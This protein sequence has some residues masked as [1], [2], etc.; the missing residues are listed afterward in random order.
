MKERRAS[1]TKLALAG[2]SRDGN[3]E[4]GARRTTKSQMRL[5]VTEPVTFMSSAK[6][7]GETANKARMS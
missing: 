2:K 5:L 7:A 1:L 3:V 4:K 6:A